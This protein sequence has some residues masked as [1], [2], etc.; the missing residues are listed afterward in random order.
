M[1]CVAPG[2]LALFCAQCWNQ[3]EGFLNGY[4]WSL[5]LLIPM[6]LGLT[7]AIVWLLFRSETNPVPL[8]EA[9]A[10]EEISEAGRDFVGVLPITGSQA[11]TLV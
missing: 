3:G 4:Y 11:R 8:P 10:A 7:G 5:L 9:S 1:S 2:L 6:A